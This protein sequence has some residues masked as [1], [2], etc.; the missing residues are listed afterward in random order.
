MQPK[1]FNN[2]PP[3]TPDMPLPEAGGSGYSLSDMPEGLEESY[4]VK[5]CQARNSVFQQWFDPYV[6]SI[7]EW[8]RISKNLIITP[9]A[10]AGVALPVGSGIVESINARLQPALLNRTK[11]AEAVPE[12]P[13]DD[14]E[15]TSRIED[16]VNQ[17]VLDRTRKVETGKQAIKSAIVESFIVWRNIWRQETIKKVTPTPILDPAFVPDPMNPMLQPQVIGTEDVVTEEMKGYWDWELKSP[18]NVAWDPH[19]ISRIS[20]SPWVREKSN[21]SFNQLKGWER[22]GIIKDVDRLRYVVPKNC[23]STMKSGW[24]EEIRRADGDMNWNFTYADEKEYSVEE[25]WADLSWKEGDQPVTKKMTWFLVEGAFVFGLQENYLIPQRLPYDSCPFVLDV[26]SLMGQSAIGTVTG[27]QAQINNMAGYQ[28]AL[29]ERL[30]KPTIFYDESSGLSNRT[31]FVKM[32]GMQPVQ[33]V[34]GIREMVMDSGPVAAVQAYINFLIGL[35]REASGANEQFQ[36]VEGADTLGEFQGLAAAAG[37]R[38]ADTVD[39]LSQ[40]WL[41]ALATECFLFTRQFVNDGDAVVRAANTEGKAEIL[42]RADFAP[43]Y[44]FIASSSSNEQS[45]QKEIQAITQ[46]MEIQAKM[47]PSPDGMVLNTQKIWTDILLPMLGQKNGA[48]WFIQAP[49]APPM[50]AP[51]AGP[52]MPIPDMPTPEGAA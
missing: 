35:A 43:D 7:A 49:M 45:K 52:E 46:A 26:H 23:N 39:T 32:F 36:G 17:S 42:S 29:T 51:G 34:Q 48:D 10:S 1:T 16:F 30:A 25:W 19:T 33:N 44:T 24:E 21:M 2:Q 37:Q 50:G 5:F 20:K 31:S 41:E 9:K 6:K 40:G 13:T 18:A 38:F 27:I 11:L 15:A 28:A 22:A 3:Q 14:N 47:G 12:F 4:V 8:H